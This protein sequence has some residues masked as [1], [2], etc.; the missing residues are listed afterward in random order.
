MGRCFAE[1]T[2]KLFIL[3]YILKYSPNKFSV[4]PSL[5]KITKSPQ[6][7]DVT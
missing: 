2:Y 4:L 3:Y 7:I 1:V 5:F 6:N